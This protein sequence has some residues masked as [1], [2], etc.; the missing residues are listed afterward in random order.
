[1]N[2]VFCPSLIFWLCSMQPMSGVVWAKPSP[3]PVV[4]RKPFIVVWNM[5]TAS[6]EERYGVELPLGV[7]DIV[8]NADHQFQGQ[9]MTIFYRNRLGFYPYIGKNGKWVNGGIPQNINMKKHLSQISLDTRESLD[10]DFQGLAV[11]DWEEWRPLWNQNWGPKKVYQ[12]ASKEWVIGK[13]PHL[14]IEKANYLAKL[15]F[16]KAARNVMVK[17]LN[18]GQRL[19]PMGLWGFYGLPECFNYDYKKEGVDYDGRCQAAT[20]GKNNQLTWLW[21]ESTAIFPSIY[22]PERLKNS[23]QGLHYVHYRVKE[24]L[25]VAEF[26]IRDTTTPVLPYSRVTYKHSLRFL[27]E[28]DL[29][30][31]IGESAA[32]GAAGVVLWGG[33]PFS[34]SYKHC[35]NLRENLIESL[36]PYVLNVTRAAD[37]CSVQLCGSNGRCQRRNPEELDAFLH[38]NPQSFYIIPGDPKEGGDPVAVGE[39]SASDLDQMGKSFQCVCYTGWVGTHCREKER[40]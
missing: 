40:S 15:E 39:P 26:S 16:E 14:P 3:N 9:N 36:G 20:V 2:L 31:T 22:L 12:R 8:E 30:H 5:P 18:A 11:V 38:L 25:R 34:S 17:T 10:A 33:N 35:K 24:A 37:V 21:E 23:E 28:V 1:M 6:C 19:R 4:H 7:F 32:M 13:F 29:V 27:S